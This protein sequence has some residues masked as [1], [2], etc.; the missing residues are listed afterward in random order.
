[1]ANGCTPTT[2]RPFEFPVS[3]I[4]GKLRHENIPHLGLVDALQDFV[5]IAKLP[6]VI[7]HFYEHTTSYRLL[8]TV[9]WKT[10]FRPFAFLYQGLSRFLQQLNLPFSSKQIEMTGS[11]VQVDSVQDS[12]PSPRAWIRTMHQ[13]TVLSP[14]IRST[15]A[16][17]RPI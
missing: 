4:R 8:A 11:I 6:P 17:K 9:Q 14:F 10:W 2:Q 1:M 13:Q 3:Q 5:D 15:Q 12:R 16:T 7:P